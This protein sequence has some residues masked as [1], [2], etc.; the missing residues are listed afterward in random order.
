MMVW[1]E[2][3]DMGFRREEEEGEEGETRDKRRRRKQTA[4]V[5]QDEWRWELE[6][7]SRIG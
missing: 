5:G 6:A 1:E 3:Y 4:R 7:D 2:K